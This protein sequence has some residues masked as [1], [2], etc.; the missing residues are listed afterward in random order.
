[1]ISDILVF[2]LE[3]CYKLLFQN[4][5]ILHSFLLIFKGSARILAALNGL[6]P[7]ARE[8]GVGTVF[9]VISSSAP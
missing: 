8:W 6:L 4:K 9:L 1:M 2:P 3:Q 5:F 7:C